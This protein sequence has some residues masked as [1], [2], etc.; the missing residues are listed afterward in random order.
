MRANTIAFATVNLIVICDKGFLSQPMWMMGMRNSR[1]TFPLR[2][3]ERAPGTS[4]PAT[5]RSDQEHC[6]PAPAAVA[7]GEAETPVVYC[8]LPESA[9]LPPADLCAAWGV[10]PR[11]SVLNPQMC[12]EEKRWS[13]EGTP[14][15]APVLDAAPSAVHI[16]P[17]D[18]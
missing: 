5:G 1:W 17:A 6:L 18:F 4:K 16:P 15:G 9:S 3:Q 7:G 12:D 2:H 13:Q 10:L 14:R 8:G 11:L